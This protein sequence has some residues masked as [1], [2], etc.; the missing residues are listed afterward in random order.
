MS[1]HQPLQD[2]EII[3]L[4]S[5]L[6]KSEQVEYPASSM[7]KRR[8]AFLAQ[9]ALAGSSASMQNSGARP[10]TQLRPHLPTSL[11]GW[12]TLTLAVST[13]A[14]SALGLYAYRNEILSLIPTPTPT[15]SHV[16]SPRKTSTPD[17]QVAATETQA[18]PSA[19]ESVT[20]S[21]LFTATP[22]P[23]QIDS[24]QPAQP[25]KDNHGKQ[26]GRTPR[27]KTSAPGLS[28]P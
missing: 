15:T 11:E 14:A 24:T 27:P 9:A 12:L 4:I 3:G 8:A 10:S 20:I 25:E 1:K 21:P 23:N 17:V 22:E 13:A 2:E 5:D 16:A 6:K 19:T 28:Q 26:L 7:K 18:T